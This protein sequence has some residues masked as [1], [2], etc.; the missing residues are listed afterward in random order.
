MKE[1]VANKTSI[2]FWL[3]WIIG[4]VPMFVAFAMYYTGALAP[5]NG[6]NQG[7]LISKQTLAQW[8]LTFNSN[9]WEQTSQWQVLHTQPNNCDEKD[10]ERWNSALPS[11]I[12]LLGKDSNRVVIYQVGNSASMLQ[13]AK[14]QDLGEAVWV[15]DPNGN[16]VLRYS[17][18]L[19]PEQLLKDL[20][21]LLKVSKI[22]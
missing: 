1:Q 22:G 12:K 14:L 10:C 3:I 6:V 19:T 17:P 20:K 18:E 8:Q 7:E 5:G 2:S 16:L 11:V 13:T 4:V 9:N 21:K 15:V